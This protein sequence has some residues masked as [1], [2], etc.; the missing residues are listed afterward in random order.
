M[1][2]YL[3]LSQF[4]SPAA[5]DLKKDES[6]DRYVEF[7]KEVSGGYDKAHD[8]TH[9]E[10][11]VRQAL[12]VCR[13][14]G[15]HGL[16]TLVEAAAYGHELLD[17]K[18][19]NLTKEVLHEKLLKFFDEPV[20]EILLFVIG[21]V[22]FSKVKAWA[23]SGFDW[24]A[25]ASEMMLNVRT[26]VSDADLMDAVGRESDGED[27]IIGYDRMVAYRTKRKSLCECSLEERKAMLEDMRNHE[28]EKLMHLH[29]MVV[30][31][32]AR[33]FLIHHQAK[34]HKKL[35]QFDWVV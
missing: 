1:W 13:E 25:G 24:R 27:S 32:Y 28:K 5:M 4:C 23:E 34:L 17:T 14:L 29:K 31:R 33:D 20:V 7:V 10:E 9:I 26:C 22:S 30:S 15:F 35:Y 3:I 6:F 11:V 8:M 16:E 21:T 2:A 12:N 19:A 18:Q